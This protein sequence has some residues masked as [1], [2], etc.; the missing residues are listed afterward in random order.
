MDDEEPGSD[1]PDSEHDRIA[2]F[3]VLA[4]EYERAHDALG[5]E[6]LTHSPVT[7]DT[8][9][10]H[11]LQVL[12]AMLLRK[13]F[14]PSDQVYLGTIANSLRTCSTGDP[15]VEMIAKDIEVELRLRITKPNGPGGPTFRDVLYGRLMHAGWN[16]FLST[17]RLTPQETAATL[18][19]GGAAVERA[20]F[21]ALDGVRLAVREG[22]LRHD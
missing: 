10:G 19:A 13:F 20:L 17:Q 5:F 3:E 11:W 2:M 12:Q 8:A 18:Y 21:A 15:R 16:Q 4:T 9:P 22:I 6:Q 14:T 7:D 1:K